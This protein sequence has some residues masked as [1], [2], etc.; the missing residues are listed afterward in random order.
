MQGGPNADADCTD[1]VMAL[2]K[3]EIDSNGC[4]VPCCYCDME[5]PFCHLILVSMLVDKGASSLITVKYK[6][7]TQRRTY[8][9]L[10]MFAVYKRN[11]LSM[12][13]V[14]RPQKNTFDSTEYFAIRHKES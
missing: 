8:C 10:T 3:G 1:N 9:M 14:V 4:L 12:D 11:Y 2:W 7:S 6:T 5:I 13:K